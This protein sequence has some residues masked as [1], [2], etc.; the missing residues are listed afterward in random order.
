MADRSKKRRNAGIRTI[1][2]LFNHAP[3]LK[4]GDDYEFFDRPE[5]SELTAKYGLEFQELI[6]MDSS[7]MYS[8]V[9]TNDVDVITA[10]STDGRIPAAFARS[11]FI[12]RA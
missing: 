7:L 8:A 9:A 4:L 3:Q 5:W 2:G 12:A 1:D 11:R 6:T 10:F